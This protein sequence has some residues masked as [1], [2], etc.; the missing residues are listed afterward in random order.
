MIKIQ[1]DKIFSINWQDIKLSIQ[2]LE[3]TLYL[4]DVN[5]KNISK[6]EEMVRKDGSKYISYVLST[7][8]IFEN[9]SNDMEIE[10]FNLFM[11]ILL[12]KNYNYLMLIL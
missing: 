7:N 3:S 11:Q 12:N 8:M 1:T 4:K 5:N 9:H 10:K 6:K 2:L